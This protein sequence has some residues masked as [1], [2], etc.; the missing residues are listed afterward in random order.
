M[1]RALLLIVIAACSA[2]DRRTPPPSPPTQAALAPL[3]PSTQQ[4]LARELDDAERRGT[5]TEVQKRWQGQVVRWEVTRIPQ[6]CATAAECH[7]VAFPV[8][9]PA[10]RGWLPRVELAPGQFAIL[11]AACRGALQCKVTIEGT[12]ARLDVSAE[13]P[14]QVRFS[15]VT[16][17]R[18]TT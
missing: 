4:D 18:K 10:Q 3:L 11:E 15:N 17:A 12:V 6:L 2:E 14:T 13:L 1:T 5:F 7:V 16:V 9:R 8:M